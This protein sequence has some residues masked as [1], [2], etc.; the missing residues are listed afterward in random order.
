MFVLQNTHTQTNTESRSCVCLC[1]EIRHNMFASHP[2][3]MRADD[4]GQSPSD[5]GSRRTWSGLDWFGLVWCV[6]STESPESVCSALVL[7]AMLPLTT[8][9]ELGCITC[10]Q[11]IAVFWMDFCF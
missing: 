1:A 2:V 4:A 8:L 10:N 6:V 5:D 3:M 9:Y 7:L 11:R